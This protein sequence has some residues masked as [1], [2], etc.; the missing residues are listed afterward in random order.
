MPKD[1]WNPEEWKNAEALPHGIQYCKGQLEIG[2]DTGYEHW[3][4]VVYFGS[5]K[6]RTTVRNAFGGR[7][8]CE[9]T[10]SEKAE[11]YVWKSETAVDGSKF[12]LGSR[13][14]KRNSKPDWDTYWH[15]AKKL[16][17][18]SEA[19]PAEFRIKYY[20]TLKRIESD[21]MELVER[22]GIVCRVYWGVTGSG[23]SH[24]AWADAISEARRLGGEDVSGW[25]DARIRT[26]L[27]YVKQSRTKWWDRYDRQKV[28]IIDDFRGSQVNSPGIAIENMLTWLDKYP[29]MVEK[30]GAQAPLH[31]ISFYITSN[32]SPKD[33]YP[34]NPECDTKALLRRLQVT[35]F[36]K[37]FSCL[38]QN[39]SD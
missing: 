8:F 25:S 11:E 38:T 16:G 5:Q 34:S 18:H 1:D 31:A 37:T 20:G 14:F 39:E 22:P 10:R 3:Q 2:A 33:W 4:L 6:R 12:E 13:S 19:I 21:F 32:L 27:V 23:K 15:A 7:A 17:V 26:E 24:K 9:P 36:S 35:H 29:C 28:V 30:K